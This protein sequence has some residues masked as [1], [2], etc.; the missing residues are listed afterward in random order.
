MRA[1]ASVV[2]RGV[3]ALMLTS[4]WLGATACESS[5]DGTRTD[6]IVSTPSLVD[7]LVCA[8]PTGLFTTTRVVVIPH[9]RPRDMFMFSGNPA[10]AI[11]FDGRQFV[12]NVFANGLPPVTNTGTFSAGGGVIIFGDEPLLPRLA[13]AS[14]RF[15]CQASNDAVLLHND[16][17]RFDFGSGAFERATV[18]A[19]FTRR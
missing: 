10:L 13:I 18:R 11:S 9:A 6:V 15:R 3:V 8:K 12:T 17:A 5:A 1:D 16:D 2:S 14:Q 7:T 19:I 4:A